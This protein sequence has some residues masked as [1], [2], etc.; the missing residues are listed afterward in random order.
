MHDQIL[1]QVKDA[2][3]PIQPA[4]S[5]RCRWN[6]G[7]LIFVIS[8]EESHIESWISSSRSVTPQTLARWDLLK[9]L[10]L[11][12]LR[13]SAPRFQM[14][15]LVLLTGS[16][17]L[18]SSMALLRIHLQLM[19]LRYMI[20][21]VI[22][23][24]VFLALVWLWI[25]S[26]QRNWKAFARPAIVGAPK[27]R[28][29]AKPTF[30]DGFGWLEWLD[31]LDLFSDELAVA[32]LAV[33]GA[34]SVAFVIWYCISAIALAPEFLAEVFLDGVCTAALYHRLRKIEHQ[35]WLK[36]V[37]AKT[38]VPFLWTLLFFAFIG[39]VSRHYAPEAIS[40]GGVLQHLTGNR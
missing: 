22:A 24:G 10:E 35:H 7:P 4:A 16:V 11:H 6:F 27:P 38:Q 19:A 13:T 14:F 18:L 3:A 2:G 5:K 32:G 37:L 23:Y 8:E 28:A 40:I 39:V 12:L 15:L 26:R 20:S 9:R 29:S 36:T 17:G 21:V 30:S 31:W 1:H 25:L 33:A 34:V